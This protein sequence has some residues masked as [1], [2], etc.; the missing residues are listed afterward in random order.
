MKKQEEKYQWIV[1]PLVSWYEENARILPWRDDANPYRVWVSEIMLQQTRVDAV[2]AYFNRFMETLP[3][4]WD[5]AK[6]DE[7]VVLKLWEG[8]GYYSRARNLKKTA[9]IVCEQYGGN[10]PQGYKELLALPGIGKYTVGS[11]SSIA[12]GLPRAAVDGN[13]LR[14]ITRLDENPRDIMDEKFRK[15]IAQQLEPVYPQGKCSEFT[16]SLMELGAMICVPNG[17][18]KCEECPLKNGCRA[19]QNGTW[20]K[21]PVKKEKP[22]RKKVNKTVFL[23]KCEGKTAIQKGEDKGLL[24]GLWKL[25]NV[26]KKLTE[27]EIKEWLEEQHLEAISIEKTKKVKHIFTHVEWHMQGYEIICRKANE[28]F[29]WATE[30]ELQEDFALPTAY[31]KIQ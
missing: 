27:K 17:A 21:Y 5:L 29:Y 13:V 12:F 6:A 14:V 23:L 25:P 10:F 4:V 28:Q 16:Q 2:I 22:K 26:E 8:L 18:P 9:E 24:A 11:I 15:E 3:T 31:K 20:E 30:K 19:N 1:E 7:S